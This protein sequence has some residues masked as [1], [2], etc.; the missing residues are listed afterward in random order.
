MKNTPQGIEQKGIVYICSK[1]AG[2]LVA[3]LEDARS[4]SKD[5]RI[6]RN[7]LAASLKEIKQRSANQK[8]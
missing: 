3:K 4:K 8:G 2:K 6:E 7:R 1:E 5:L